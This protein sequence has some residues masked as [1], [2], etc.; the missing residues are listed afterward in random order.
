M[1]NKLTREQTVALLQKLSSDD[2]YRATF[3]KDPATA[4]DQIGIDSRQLGPLP[5][6]TSTTPPLP[7]K[8]HFQEALNEVQNV[9][10]SQ[11]MCQIWPMLK[12]T[13]GDSKLS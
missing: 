1:A 12:L 6:V 7:P 10:A 11:H 3:E 4:L 9:G 2:A 8:G 5:A 13:Y